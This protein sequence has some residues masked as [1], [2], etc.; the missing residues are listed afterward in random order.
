LNGAG[1]EDTAERGAVGEKLDVRLG[2]V[3]ALI[4][5]LIANLCKLGDYPRVIDIAV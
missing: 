2:L 1:K 5:D 3:L 4:L